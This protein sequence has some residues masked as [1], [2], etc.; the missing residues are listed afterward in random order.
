MNPTSTK[1]IGFSRFFY[2]F[3]CLCCLQTRV[4]VVSL[5]VLV[6]GHSELELHYVC[7]F[8]FLTF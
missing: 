3:L 1:V 4:R 7:C 5:F 6:L 2:V 8:G